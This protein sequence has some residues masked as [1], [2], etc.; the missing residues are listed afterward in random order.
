MNKRNL[1]ALFADDPEFLRRLQEQDMSDKLDSIKAE[2]EADDASLGMVIQGEKGDQGEPGYTPIKGEDYFTPADIEEIKVGIKEEVTPVKGVDYFDGEDGKDG[3]SIMGPQ[4]ETGMAGR[5]GS[6]DAPLEIANKLNTLDEV[7]RVETIIGH[8]ELLSPLNKRIDDLS[9]TLNAKGKIDQRWHGGGLTQVSHDTTLTGSGTP[10]SPLSVVGSSPL[11]TKGDLFG[12]STQNERIPVGSD[13]Q[14]LTADSTQAL[15]VKWAAASGG[16]SSVSNSDGTL[17][18]SPTTGAVVASLNL[19]HANTF[20]AK[21]TF[22]GQASG[23]VPA[24]QANDSSGNYVAIA[25]Q[26]S[27]IFDSYN[28]RVGNSLIMTAGTNNRFLYL[29]SNIVSYFDIFGT[30]NTYSGTNTF[31]GANDFSGAN[32]FSATNTFTA[33]QNF[34]DITIGNQKKVILGTYTGG[35]TYITSN[36]TENGNDSMDFFSFVGFNFT[37][38]NG[39]SAIFNNCPIK[40]FGG[41]VVAGNSNNSFFGLTPAGNPDV[42]VALMR[43][44]AGSAE[45]NNGTLGSYADLYVN[46]INAVTGSFSTSFQLTAGGSTGYV[47]TSDSTGYGTWQAPGNPF[48]QSLN[49]SDSVSFSSISGG[50]SGITGYTIASA[51]SASSITPIA[52]GTYDISSTLGGSVTFSSGIVTAWTPAS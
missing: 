49:T 41:A 14:V 19:A 10:S 45:I 51:L 35:Q 52:D 39:R 33:N 20:T 46:G 13:N 36:I 7:L 30:G 37:T 31:S 3:K 12:F 38:N 28:S 34:D 6:P 44:G 9:N 2:I 18:I 32:T 5:D 50:G 24:F 43:N 8:K 16:V 29:S 27:R 22:T 25:Q 15:G 4:G 26:S 17:T 48:N 11:T 1:K 21:Q 42:D 23:S 40:T 47:L